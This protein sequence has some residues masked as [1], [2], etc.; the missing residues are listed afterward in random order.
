MENLSYSPFANININDPFFKTLIIDYV[1]FPDWFAKKA[2]T[3]E[4]AYVLVDDGAVQGFMYLKSE[5]GEVLDTTPPLPNAHHLKVGTFKFNGHGTRL[6]ERFIKKIFDHAIEHD[7]DDIYVTVFD[8]HEYLIRLFERYGFNKLGQKHTQNG[9]EFVLLRDMRTSSGDTYKDYPFV[10]PAGRNKYQLGIYPEFHTQLL[11]DSIFKSEAP[12]EI[13]KDVSHTN[14]IHKIFICKM[15][16]VEKLRPGDLLMIYRTSDGQGPAWYRAAMSSIGTVEEYRNIRTFKSEEDFLKYCNPYTVYTEAELKRFYSTREYVHI[17]RFTYNV[18][19]TKRV[20][21]AK[22]INEAGVDAQ[23]YPGF[24]KLTDQQF[25]KIAELGEIN[26]SFI[27][28]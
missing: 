22:L 7:V 24:L 8:K 11:P 13:I 12:H 2:A 3:G 5:I 6:G 20:I 26:E 4:C 18:A 1:E 28:D 14:S 25:K 23:A 27:V 17:I 19:M 9:T 21:R 16:G 10:F 15:Y